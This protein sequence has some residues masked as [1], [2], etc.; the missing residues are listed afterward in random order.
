M[1]YRRP[2]PALEENYAD[3]DIEILLRH[4]YQ[5]CGSDVIET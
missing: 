4:Q 1:K 2:D 3:R 5:A